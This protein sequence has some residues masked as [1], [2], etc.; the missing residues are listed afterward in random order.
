MPF[1]LL[2]KIAD[3]PLRIRGVAMTSGI[4]RNF[5]VYTPEE[6]QAFASKLVNSPVYNEHVSVENAIGKVTKADWDGHA[7]WYEAEIYES[8]VANKIRKG[9]RFQPSGG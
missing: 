9:G 4:S 3:K 6:L 5:N 8:E 7:L 2:E 1:S